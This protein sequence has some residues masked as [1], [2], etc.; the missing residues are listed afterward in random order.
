MDQS[1][2]IHQHN[3]THGH[4]R[5]RHLGQTNHRR[6]NHWEPPPLGC[7]QTTATSN[8]TW[9]HMVP[10]YNDMPAPLPEPHCIKATATTEPIPLMTTTLYHPHWDLP[11]P[12]H[13]CG[14]C[15]KRQKRPAN[16]LQATLAEVNIEARTFGWHIAQQQRT[17]ELTGCIRI[18]PDHVDQITQRSGEHGIIY[19]QVGAKKETAQYPKR[20]RRKPHSLL[21]TR[22]WIRTQRQTRR[23][24]PSRFGD[25]HSKAP[26]A[27]TTTRFTAKGSGPSA[28]ETWLTAPGF[29]NITAIGPPRSR[30]SPW[31]FNATAPTGDNASQQPPDPN[32]PMTYQLHDTN[33]E[34]TFSITG[35][36]W[37]L[38]P[39][40]PHPSASTPLARSKWITPIGANNRPTTTTATHTPMDTSEA[41]VKRPTEAHASTAQTQKKKQKTE[42]NTSGT[43]T[44]SNNAELP[45]LT[46]G[47][48]GEDILELGGAGDWSWRAA[49]AAM[50][51]A[52]GK[53]SRCI[54]RYQQQAHRHGHHHTNK[55]NHLAPSQPKRMATFLG[56]RPQCHNHHRIRTRPKPSKWI[57]VCIWNG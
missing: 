23:S 7:P 29:T 11:A 6:K 37:Q 56:C 36:L 48:H 39:R 30:R 3:H 32:T 26:A 17:T 45:V 55:S 54:N 2:S 43:T 57:F 9:Y 25:M 42:A 28:L 24:T 27:K 12:S 10:L 22:H 15:Y 46:A 40:Q 50:A 8:S 1:T 13:T 31:H 53:N 19:I 35:K 14:L 38:A 20:D 4:Q 49:A 47:P 51:F 34:S 44:G 5:S 41:P 18:K 21:P 52:N 16:M 33:G